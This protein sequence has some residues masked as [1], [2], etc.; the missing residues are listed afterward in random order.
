MTQT[1]QNYAV[2]ALQRRIEAAREN[3]L[4]MAGVKAAYRAAE[5][6]LSRPKEEAIKA[7]ADAGGWTKVLRG[8]Y[9]K[10]VKCTVVPGPFNAV[11]PLRT[12]LSFEDIQEIR[13]E[14]IKKG[15]QRTA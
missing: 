8:A 14:A 9:D 5:M 2:V 15:A 13:N 10:V 3:P 7:L 4:F 1:D 6:I 12:V 11:I